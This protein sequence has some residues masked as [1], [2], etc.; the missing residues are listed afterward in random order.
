MQTLCSYKVAKQML[1]KEKIAL[2]K[3]QISL[4]IFIHQNKNE[5]ISFPNK[6]RIMAASNADL[7]CTKQ[8][9]EM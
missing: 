6:K 4:D 9:S 3:T 1:F 2:N 8:R 5:Q 7:A